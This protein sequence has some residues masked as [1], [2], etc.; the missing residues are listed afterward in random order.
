MASY[1][2]EVI[3]A[4]YFSST[5]GRTENNQDMWGGSPLPYLISVVDPGATSWTKSFTRPDFISALGFDEITSVRIVSRYVSG[6]PSD[7]S[8][9]GTKAGTPATEHFTGN[10]LKALLGL[11]SHQIRS[12]GYCGPPLEGDSLIAYDAGG[13]LDAVWRGE[14]DFCVASIGNVMPAADLVWNGYLGG[15]FGSDVLLYEKAS[16]RFQFIELSGNGTSLSVMKDL[17]GSRNWSHVVPGDFNGDGAVDLLF[18]RT[19]DGLMRFYTVTA[20]GRFTPISEALYGTRGWTH[21][22]PGDFD[23]DGRDDVLWYRAGDGLMRFYSISDTG[24]FFPMT[25]AMYGNRNWSRIPSGD[26][27]GNGSDDLLYYRADGLARFYTVTSQGRFTAMSAVL[28]LSPGWDQ[29]AT[30]AFDGVTGE[31][32]AWYRSDGTLVATGYSASGLRG[33][34]DPQTIDPSRIIA[35][36]DPP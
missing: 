31:D 18:Y 6:T 14:V 17:T 28:T 26:F 16:G 35:T 22:V 4:F 34:T 19:S 10:D 24:R 11:R 15:G 5:G 1:N 32:L 20:S 30:G 9:T 23:D 25:E 29:I 12:I 33:I 3:T 21:L 7:V 2:G 27:D 36:L 13:T 8:V